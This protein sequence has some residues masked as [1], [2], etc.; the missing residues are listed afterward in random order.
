MR[1]VQAMVE[2][3]AQKVGFGPDDARNASLEL[4]ASPVLQTGPHCLLL[5]EPD[6]FYTHL[7]SMM[8]LQST[9]RR[10][11]IAYAGSTMSFKESAKKGPGWLRLEGEAL[12]LF[13]LPRSQMD[14]RSICC[15]DGPYRFALANSAG[16]ETPNGAAKRLLAELP[17]ALFS[18]A[19]E[20]IKAANYAL[21]SSHFGN[22]ENLL[23][24]DD[25]DVADLIADHLDDPT[26]WLSE[27]FNAE[28]HTPLLPNAM[29]RLNAGPWRGW[30]RRTT[31]YFWY[32]GPDRVLPLVLDGGYLKGVAR[33]DIT[34]KFSPH[35]IANEIRD[36]KLLPTLFLAFLVLSVLPGIRAL[37]GCRQ[38]VYLPL[39][40]HLT[41]LC[42]ERS[43]DGDLLNVLQEDDHPGMWGHRVLRPASGDPFHDVEASGGISTLLEIYGSERLF[44]ASGDL[45]SFTGD[46]LWSEMTKHLASG[47]IKYSSAEWK[48]SG[49]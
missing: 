24:I 40:R 31:D 18:S 42:V 47:E 27:F 25:F 32:V 22:S 16:T 36:R 8:G 19:A 34:V 2:R 37:G 5:F 1:L 38:P 43:G 3:V 14:G 33:P 41:A 6:A 49:V 48:W 29:D 4:A 7:F 12:N 28:A 23:Q 11:H 9:G 17:P 44:E 10:W 21:W 39:L 13:G 26:S 45:A 46:I 35:D 15:F 20:A 30:V